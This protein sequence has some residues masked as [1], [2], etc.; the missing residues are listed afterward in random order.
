[1][2]RVLQ[3]LRQVAGATSLGTFD[4]DDAGEAGGE[5][6]GLEDEEGIDEDI[7]EINGFDIAALDKD[8]ENEWQEVV[9][10]RSRA[11]GSRLPKSVPRLEQD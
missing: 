5:G 2:E 7:S 6:A 4:E 3:L 11:S 10:R 8:E 1:M 9:L